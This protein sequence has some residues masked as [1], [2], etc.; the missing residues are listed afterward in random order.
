MGPVTKRVFG[1]MLTMLLILANAPFLS[2]AE[3]AVIEVNPAQVNITAKQG[4]SISMNLGVYN[5]GTSSLL[6]ALSKSY[7]QP[8]TTPTLAMNAQIMVYPTFLDF[9]TVPPKGQVTQTLTCTAP[10]EQILQVNATPDVTWLRCQVKNIEAAVVSVSVTAVLDEMVAGQLYRGNIILSSNAGMI[11]V[12]VLLQVAVAGQIDWLSYNPPNGFVEPGK[13][14]AVT[15]TAKTTGMQ[16]GDYYAILIV[17]S[18]D[19]NKP[20]IEVPVKLTL[21]AGSPPPI[22]PNPFVAY[23]GDGRVHLFWNPSGSQNVVG[24]FIY[25]ATYPNGQTDVAITDFHISGT[26]YTDSNIVNTMTYYYTIRAVDSF[27]NLSQPSFEV[28]VTPN[29]IKPTV[30][31]KDGMVTRNQVL[32]ITG[33]AESNSQIVVNGELA[34][35]NPDGNYSS[36]AILKT[37]TNTISIIVFDPGGNK[38][39]F[40]FKVSF[41]AFTSIILMIG[42]KNAFVNNEELKNAL[43]VAPVIIKGKTMIPFRF[44]GEKLGANIGWEPDTKKITYELEGKSIEMWIGNTNALVNGS[45]ASCD[46]APTIVGGSTVVPTRFVTENLGASVQWYS[47]TKTVVITYPAKP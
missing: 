15:I 13:N 18:N 39:P 31:L 29:P 10:G 3:G 8:K 34:L 4:E 35:I 26:S 14:T 12:P 42:S 47:A 22:A 32:E 11:Q 25:R 2:A 24:Y 37:G 9:G 43:S 33:H 7:T 38:T 21:I 6:F 40:S 19:P 27:G 44:I 16:A 28:N 46:P 20:V 30:N 36:R 17:T 5:K 23:P 1:L 45:R 41:A